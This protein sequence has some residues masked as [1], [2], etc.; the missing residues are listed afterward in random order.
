[1]QLAPLRPVDDLRVVPGRDGVEAERQGITVSD[2]EI[3]ERILAM[4]TFQE[5]GVFIG[6]QRYRQVLSFQSP[7]LTTA[8]F[9]AQL[10][11][12]IAVEKLRN[13]LTAWMTITDAEIAALASYVAGLQ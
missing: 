6:E 7:P 2:V 11:R 10:R 3:R 12:A 9:E 1:M 13:A 4:P 5:N 8:E